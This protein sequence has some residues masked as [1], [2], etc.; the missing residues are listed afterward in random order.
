MTERIVLC[1]KWGPLFPAD[2]VNVLFNACRRNLTGAFRFVCLTD[3]G[4]GLVDGIE[5][6]PIPDIGL[7]PEQW[8][9]PGVWPKLA[10]FAPDLNGL[11]GRALFIDLDMMILGPLD[12]FF[13]AGGGLVALD[14]GENWRPGAT[15]LKPEAGTGVI[16]YDL[17]SQDH[18]LERFLAD[19]AAVMRDFR[20]EQDFVGANARDLRFWP[21]GWVISFKRHVMRRLGRDMIWPPAPPTGAAIL[22]FHGNPRPIDLLRPGLWG[23]FPHIGRGP[24][25]WVRDYWV[26]NGGRVDIGG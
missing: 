24:V 1:M 9:T 26:E 10:L 22:A 18:I 5:A 3:R 2:Y 12:P 11:K 15:G 23:P 25:G 4:E 19:R 14:V 17:G 8:Y 7:T 16:A 20:N 13:E 6:L 21:E